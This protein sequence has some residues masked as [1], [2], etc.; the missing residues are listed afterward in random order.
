M[1]G[2]RDFYRS[3][4]TC[5]VTIPLFDNGMYALLVVNLALALFA[6][7]MSFF[8]PAIL[9][10]TNPS[11]YSVIYRVLYTLLVFTSAVKIF[12]VYRSQVQP[13]RI[14]RNVA[15]LLLIG[16]FTLALTSII[17]TSKRH[18]VGV[19]QCVDVFT[20]KVSTQETIGSTSGAG[21][22]GTSGLG[23]SS[24]SAKT[25]VANEIC[26]VF[27]WLQVGVASFSWVA[28]IVLQLYFASKENVFFSLKLEDAIEDAKV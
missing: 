12:A 14:F 24:D 7:I 27:A 10:V 3:D 11:G 22:L 13:F 16:V 28:M 1:V 6:A 19:E 25:K 2:F 17:I 4:R 21:L 20:W 8:G 18:S 5:C 23:G 26:S 9:T 15:F